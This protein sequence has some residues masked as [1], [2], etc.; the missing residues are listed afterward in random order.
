MTTTYLPLSKI[1]TKSPKTAGKADRSSSLIEADHLAS[2]SQQNITNN[3]HVKIPT[4]DKNDIDPSQADNDTSNNINSEQITMITP[5]TKEETKPSILKPGLTSINDGSTPL[6]SKKPA[7]ITSSIYNLSNTAVGA[8]ILALPYATA[9]VGW[10]LGLVLFIGCAIMTA[11]TL[12]INS[13]AAKIYRPRSSYKTLCDACIKYLSYFADFIIAINTFGACCAY[14]II[15][16]KLWPDI[17]RFF[18]E[19]LDDIWYD[20]RIWIAIYFVLFIIPCIYWRKLDAL[21]HVSLIAMLCYIYIT[22][23]VLVYAIIGIDADKH[24]NATEKGDI[25]AVPYEPL[26]FFKVS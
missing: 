11:Y 9:Q 2:T 8:G 3:G 26:Q 1:K 12:H 22:I 24:P 5:T 18:S 6:D 20:R 15:V 10:F 19:D 25:S 16:G 17:I 14:L 13:M 21:R 7:S 4:T 23:V